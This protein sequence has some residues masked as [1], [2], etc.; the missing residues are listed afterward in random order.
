MSLI[1]WIIAVA[2]IVGPASILLMMRSRRVGREFPFFLNYLISYTLIAAVGL[3]AYFYSCRIYYYA[4]WVLTVLLISMEF[5]VIYEVLKHTLKPYSALADFATVMFRWAAG[6]LL[7]TALVTAL[8]TTGPQATKLQAAMNVV[9]HTVRLMECGL[10]LFLL[11]FESRLGISWRSHG[12]SIAIGLGVYSAVDLSV[13]YLLSLSPGHNTLFGA[14]D[15]FVFVG[16]LAFWGTFLWLPEPERKTVLDSPARLIFQRWNEALMATPLVA[17]QNQMPL[18]PIE[19]FLP[20]VEQTVE[21][22][23]ARK[24]H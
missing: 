5:G 11:I 23:L 3:A 10:L 13:S 15:G 21:R 17:R 24:M 18:S 9:E 7:L 20:G 14:I 2:G 22:V 19:S 1:Q 12:T 4:D 16:V 8:S 6:F